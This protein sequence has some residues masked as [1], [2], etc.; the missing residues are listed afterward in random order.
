M[1]KA[2][3]AAEKALALDNTS[4]EAHI[5]LANVQFNYYWDWDGAEREF[6]R[7]LKLS[8]NYA[9]GYHWHSNLLQVLGHKEEGIQEQKKAAALDPVSLIVNT[10]LCRAYLFAKQLD[11]AIQQCHKAIELD[12][13]FW[14]AS[15]WLLQ[16]L[17][18]EGAYK[19]YAEERER[20]F[21]ALGDP[22]AAEE[23]HRIF[24]A[25]GIES[26]TRWEARRDLQSAQHRFRMQSSLA[27]AYAVLGDRENALTC[28]EKSYQERD[29]GLVLV[30]LIETYAPLRSDPRYINIRR[31]MNLPD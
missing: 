7:G 24:S 18:Q 22:K 13:A 11:A 1:P 9:L 31:K 8:P 16:A 26:L 27:R 12:P 17:L 5:A 15:R 23:V 2:K 4:G 28:L 30:G 14:V 3:A 6:Q 25:G 19:E 21:R 29:F 20:I 10:N